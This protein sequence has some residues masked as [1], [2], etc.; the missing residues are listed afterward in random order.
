MNHYVNQI[1]TYHE[2]HKLHR[3]GHSISYISD[4]LGM[5]WR[6]V[7]KYLSMD[8]REF[9]NFLNRPPNRKK[10]LSRYEHFVHSK[11]KLFP[12]TSAAQMHDW[13]KEHHD[14][15]P[16]VSPKTVFNFVTFVR[17]EHH[18]P[19][20]TTHRQFSMT[21]ELPYGKQAQV[22]FGE[23]NI[24]SST[25]KRT[26]VYFFTMV[27][28]RS[29]YKFVWFIDRPFTASLA[30]QAHE[31]TFTYFRGIPDEI[32]Y[33]Q[34]KVFMVSENGGDIILTDKFQNYTRQRSFTLHFCRKADPQ[35]KG[36]VENVVKYV[37]QNFLYNRTYFNTDTLNDEAIAWLGRTANSKPH[38]TTL[39]IPFEEKQKE[40]PFLQSYHP[41]LIQPAKETYAVRKDNAISYK[42]NFYS[43]PLGTFKGKGTSVWV[44][45]HGTTLV[46]TDTLSEQEI[47]RHTIPTG[48]G[49]KV[50]NTDHKRDK[51]T[52]I[53]DM[54]D[55]VAR[56]FT[57]PQQAIAWLENI[58]TDKPRY[59]RD[60]LIIIREAVVGHDPEMI[61]QTVEYCTEQQIYSA[62]DFKNI[63]NLPQNHSSDKME[64][65]KVNPLSGQTLDNAHIQPDKSDINDYQS[66]L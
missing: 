48:K 17:Q 66:I 55:E 42:G 18:L 47:C 59:I 16:D 13:L 3:Q 49:L 36:K 62:T 10:M 32:V 25:G 1:M 46:I 2:I 4:Y 44:Q 20:T 33:D 45:V 22:D 37:K 23:Y 43:L 38:G 51:S 11:L 60:Q 8:D 63:L 58:R 26:K 5:N 27:L 19:K 39:K 41:L 31:K 28:S 30:I 61:T 53:S 65:S 40:Q 12:D 64:V 9:D 34:D 56:L 6:T 14:D 24:R 52:S 15:F 21:E 29:R 57:D 54:L 35:S 7:K 50:S